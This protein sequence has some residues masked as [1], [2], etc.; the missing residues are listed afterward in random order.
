VG[1]GD[2][3]NE[4]LARLEFLT[5]R[6]HG[7]KEDSY[8]ALGD[9]VRTASCTPRDWYGDGVGV[10]RAVEF[11]PLRPYVGGLRGHCVYTVDF[12]AAT[13]V[14]VPEAYLRPGQV[15]ERS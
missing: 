5:A 14:R 11:R 8:F 1:V 13:G 7:G 10:V 15:D 2:S 4:A 12:D 6:D 9:L 3:P